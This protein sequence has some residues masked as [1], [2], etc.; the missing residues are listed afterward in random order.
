V[1]PGPQ[2]RM[3]YQPSGLTLRAIKGTAPSPEGGWGRV[4]TGSR[5]RDNR[6]TGA[7]ESKHDCPKAITVN[8]PQWKCLP[9]YFWH[10]LC[11]E[12]AR[13]GSC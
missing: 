5:S 2:T 4:A 9:G 11:P 1:L 8:V 3:S 10:L 7:A 13:K 12:P 6:D